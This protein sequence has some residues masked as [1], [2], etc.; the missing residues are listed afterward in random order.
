MTTTL[1]IKLIKII[2]YF[3]LTLRYRLLIIQEISN[4]LLIEDYFQTNHIVSKVFSSYE[5]FYIQTQPIVYR[6]LNNER[7]C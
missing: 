7:I 5:T 3:R 6:F 1:I 2:S 4:S